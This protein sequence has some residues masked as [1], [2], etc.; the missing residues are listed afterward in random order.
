MPLNGTFIGLR[1]RCWRVHSWVVVGSTSDQT[2]LFFNTRRQFCGYVG[3]HMRQRHLM[4]FILL[5][6]FRFWRMEIVNIVSSL[7]RRSENEEERNISSRENNHK[8]GVGS[9]VVSNVGASVTRTHH[10]QREQTVVPRITNRGIFLV[11]CLKSSFFVIPLKL[12][13]SQ[14]FQDNP[15]NVRMYFLS[16]K[17]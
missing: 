7:F 9:L 11:Q 17:Y 8:K 13:T 1:K 15:W 14:T 16:S 6:M 4:F 2:Q 10:T 3:C 12:H 5:H